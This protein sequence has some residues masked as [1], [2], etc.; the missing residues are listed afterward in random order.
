MMCVSSGNFFEQSVYNHNDAD[1]IPEI[2]EEIIRS[3]MVKH[4]TNIKPEYFYIKTIAA[5]LK[6][7]F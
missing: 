3:P 1:T 4:F 5:V 2:F 7:S 6:M